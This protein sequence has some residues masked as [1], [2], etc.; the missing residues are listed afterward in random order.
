MAGFQVTKNLMMHDAGQ[1]EL[2]FGDARLPFG[3]T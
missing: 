1:V 3:A 2:T